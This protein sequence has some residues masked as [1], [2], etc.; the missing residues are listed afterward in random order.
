MVTCGNCILSIHLY[1]LCGFASITLFGF[2]GNI[3]AKSNTIFWLTQELFEAIT[4][5][6]DF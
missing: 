6:A 5:L 2:F 1:T 4:K 3:L